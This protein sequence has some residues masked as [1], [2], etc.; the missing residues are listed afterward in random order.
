MKIHSVSSDERNHCYSITLCLKQLKLCTHLQD[1]VFAGTGS[2]I[3]QVL[4][5]FE[6]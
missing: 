1:S 6:L 5:M 2:G 4:T 3:P